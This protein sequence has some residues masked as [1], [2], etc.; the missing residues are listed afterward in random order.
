MQ[1]VAVII[2][3]FKTPEKWFVEALQSIYEVVHSTNSLAVEVIIVDDASPLAPPLVDFP[4]SNRFKIQI[5]RH[6]RNRGVSAARNTGLQHIGQDGWV[7]FMDSDDLM[8]SVPAVESDTMVIGDHLFFGGL[9]ED[10]VVDERDKSNA[11]DPTDFNRL[12]YIRNSFPISAYFIPMSLIRDLKFDSSLN[13]CEDWDFWLRLSENVLKLKR[14]IIRSGQTVTAIR[15]HPTSMSSNASR[16]WLARSQ[17]FEQILAEE[18][19]D[20]RF[21]RYAARV[22]SKLG[23]VIFSTVDYGVR[24]RL[25][26]DSTL[27][28]LFSPKSFKILGSVLQLCLFG[29]VVGIFPTVGKYVLERRFKLRSNFL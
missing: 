13:S 4:R 3:F 20:L 15:K 23:R 16:I 1:N 11:E 18:F 19:S 26:Y 8:L 24:A 6:E 9:A 28:L 29:W 14:P 27:L 2:P 25:V 10:L 17:M 5:I 12:L 22:N 21:K 7:V